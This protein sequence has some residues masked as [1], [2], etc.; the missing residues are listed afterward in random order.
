[1]LS[2]RAGTSENQTT[3]IV[4]RWLSPL[5]QATFNDLLKTGSPLSVSMPGVLP[6]TLQMLQT[7]CYE[8]TIP[9]N[10]PH[11]VIIN[12]KLTNCKAF[13]KTSLVNLAQLWVLASDL[14]IPRLQ[15][16][17]MNMMWHDVCFYYTVRDERNDPGEGFMLQCNP[18]SQEDQDTGILPLSA[19]TDFESTR[20][21]DFWD[22]KHYVDTLKDDRYIPLIVYWDLLDR[23]VKYWACQTRAKSVAMGVPEAGGWLHESGGTYNGFVPWILLHEDKI[24][25]RCVYY[26][27]PTSGVLVEEDKYE[28]PKECICVCLI[29]DEDEDR[30]EDEAFC[31]VHPHYNHENE[32]EKDENGDDIGRHKARTLRFPGEGFDGR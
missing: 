15:N 6:S 25:E 5:I 16:E 12:S 3:T 10:F 24:Y 20:M 8:D 2:I 4:P 21:T 17:V 23:S 28:M 26:R 18:L 19:S 1:M 13:H 14:E 29:E 9:R 22:F 7:W 30:S 11:M 27:L 31:E 32:V